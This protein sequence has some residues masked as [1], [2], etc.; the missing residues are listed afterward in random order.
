MLDWK[1]NFSDT[2]NSYVFDINIPSTG[3]QIQYKAID[4]QTL[5]KLL[6]Y[7]R[8][9]DVII[10][11]NMLDELIRSSVVSPENIDIDSMLY[12]DRLFLL[13]AIRAKSKGESI[14]QTFICPKC[15]GQSMQN[16]A[17]SDMP[18]IEYKDPEIKTIEVV[19]GITLELKHLSRGDQRL[20]YEKILADKS[21]KENEREIYAPLYMVASAIC[22]YDNGVVKTPIENIEDKIFIFEKLPTSALDKIKDWL[23]INKFGLEFEFKK[24]CPHCGYEENQKIETSG[25][26]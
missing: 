2:I 13:I 1:Q 8:S 22:G 10:L 6:I 3:Q 25:V 17:F 24:K 21:I 7:E 20:A 15:E 5:K 11:E 9:D 19:K 12:Y 23:E 26:F 18:Y 14:S 4:T 16:M